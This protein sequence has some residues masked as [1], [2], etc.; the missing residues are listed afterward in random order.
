MVVLSKGPD[1]VAFLATGRL[2]A[3]GKRK[4]SGSENCGQVVRLQLGVPGDL[5]CR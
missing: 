1:A 2:T 4:V 5:A 3:I